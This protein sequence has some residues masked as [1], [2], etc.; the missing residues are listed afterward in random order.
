MFL[1]ACSSRLPPG[2]EYFFLPSLSPGRMG[3]ECAHPLCHGPQPPWNLVS[4]LCSSSLVVLL[5]LFTCYAFS[6]LLLIY[7]ISYCSNISWIQPELWRESGLNSPHPPPITESIPC[8]SSQIFIGTSIRIIGFINYGNL[9]PDGQDKAK[10][11]R[12]YSAF[13]LE[14]SNFY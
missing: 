14:K 2:F 7:L 5:F 8:L 13:S 1:T 12:Q 3:R 4:F 11:K 10:Q 6:C 9:L